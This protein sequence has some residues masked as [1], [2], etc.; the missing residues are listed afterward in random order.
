[1]I[2]ISSACQRIIDDEIK[3]KLKA[4]PATNMASAADSSFK[5]TIKS[6]SKNGEDE[7]RMFVACKND[8]TSLD[9]LKNNIR[10]IFGLPMGGIKSPSPNLPN[11]PPPNFA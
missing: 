9:S 10:K 11:L 4:K 7:V 1:L 6:M 5:V 2:T 8:L 3:A